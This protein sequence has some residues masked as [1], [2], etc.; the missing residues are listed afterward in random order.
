[1]YLYRV[2]DSEGNTIDF[3]VN[4]KRDA[5]AAKYFLMK[6]LAS[7]HATK[8]RP[9]KAA[10][11]KAYPVAV[12]ELKEEKC[13]PLRVQNMPTISLNKT[14]VLSKSVFRICLD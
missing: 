11:D 13:I 12:C 10:G 14:T 2:I 1:M 8:P 5:K 4:R 6:S 9:I 7:C 3:Y